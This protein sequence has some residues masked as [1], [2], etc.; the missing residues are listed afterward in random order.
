VNLSGSEKGLVAD[1][2]GHVHEHSGS[3][4]A[5]NLLTSWVTVSFSKRAL[6]H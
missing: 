6:L 2:S 3:T 5:G 1:F 4:N